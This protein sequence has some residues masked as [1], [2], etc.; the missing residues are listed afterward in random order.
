LRSGLFRLELG[1]SG[2]CEESEL[3]L[4]RWTWVFRLRD[5][6][7]GSGT[8]GSVEPGAS[9]QLRGAWLRRGMTLHYVSWRG[10]QVGRAGLVDKAIVSIHPC[11]LCL[12][13]MDVES[14][15]QRYINVILDGFLSP[16]FRDKWHP[17]LVR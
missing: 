5:E 12:E 15:G 2:R 17:G 9:A 4:G 10:T 1:L 13:S 16:G 6:E 11:W 7:S 8:D 3:G 14:H